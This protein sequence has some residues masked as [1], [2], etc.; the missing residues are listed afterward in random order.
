[1]RKEQEQYNVRCLSLEFHKLL[2][3]IQGHPY[4][5]ALTDLELTVAY[6]ACVFSIA[7]LEFSKAEQLITN[8]IDNIFHISKCSSGSSD[9]LLFWRKVSERLQTCPKFHIYIGSLFI[10]HWAI[11]LA[12]EKYHIVRELEKEI[13]LFDVI[14]TENQSNKDV[15]ESLLLVLEPKDLVQLLHIS[16]IIK[17]GAQR[18]IDHQYLEALSDM[19]RASSLSA[20]RRLVACT[21]LISGSCFAQMKHPHMAL[22][23]FRKA[24]ETDCHCV[25]AL[26]QSMLIYR[27]LENKEAEINALELLHRVLNATQIPDFD[28][29][30][31][32]LIS[33]S[34]LLS[35]PSLKNLLTVPSAVTLLH[36]LALRCVIHGRVS[37]GVEHYLD[38]LASLQTDQQRSSSNVDFPALPWLTHLFLE[39]AATM[40]MAQRPFDCMALC[41]EV[42]DTTLD[43]MPKR[44]E[45]EGLDLEP[46]TVPGESCVNPDKG[47]M[48]LWVGAAYFLQGHCH[49][50]LKDWKQAITFYSRCIELLVR[51]PFKNKD[52]DKGR[53]LSTLQRLKAF[54]FAGRGVCFAQTN[55]L[56][57][58]LRDLQLSLHVFPE[59]AFAARWCGEVLW[60][61][62][63]RHEAANFW[64]TL[65]DLP[66]TSSQEYELISPFRRA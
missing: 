43:L 38:L 65:R 39:A 50:H 45:L 33:S 52:M 22:I 7:L 53:K 13:S 58:S 56:K 64:K 44:L 9:Y 40:L 25:N 12:T 46:T 42:V 66:T 47:T 20:P 55:L 29:E 11:W 61:L 32:Q 41:D 37:E 6:N 2:S 28:L 35:S 5:A 23:C 54:S 48:M 26:Y 49:I 3:K 27:Q 17:Q 1:M 4:L 24:L 51:L 21:H 8:T 60:R 57:E 30:N 16:T 59:C 31:G 34:L 15:Y 36:S 18:L 62:E 10:L 14:L 19:K 63:R